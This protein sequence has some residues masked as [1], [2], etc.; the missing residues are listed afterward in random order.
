MSN[1]LSEDSLDDAFSQTQKYIEA[2]AEVKQRLEVLA[3]GL[4]RRIMGTLADFG[5]A[6]ILT[7]RANDR[8]YCIVPSISS[9]FLDGAEDAHSVL[10]RLQFL[11]DGESIVWALGNLLEE[12]TRMIRGGIAKY[13][14]ADTLF[15][16]KKFDSLPL[17]GDIQAILDCMRNPKPKEEPA[18]EQQTHSDL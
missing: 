4:E 16:G 12:R 2:Y 11:V 10:E 5:I 3:S 13:N 1:L 14:P 9:V 17:P 7:V 15:Q 18:S 6:E 8:A